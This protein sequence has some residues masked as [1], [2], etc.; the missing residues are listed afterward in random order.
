MEPALLKIVTVLRLLSF[1]VVLYLA[2][3]WLAERYARKPDGKVR[4]FFRL[5]C[6]PVTAPIARLLPSGAGERRVLEVSL[7]VVGGLWVVL[8]I[9]SEALRG[10]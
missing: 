7:G 6:R 9:V 4:G 10:T 8:I 5:V 2:L 1:M 3:G